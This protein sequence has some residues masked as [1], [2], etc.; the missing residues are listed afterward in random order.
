M[1]SRVVMFS[2]LAVV[3]AVSANPLAAQEISVEQALQDRILG[4]PG[5]PIAIVEYASFT[6]PQCA[7]FH[8]ETMPELK[9][10]WIDTGKAKLIYRDFPLDKRAAAASVVA[11]C[12]PPERYF[13]I[14]DALYE[15]QDSWARAADSASS[16]AAVSR[17]TGLSS[18]EIEKCLGNQP[19]V[20]GV[21]KMRLDAQQTLGIKGTP[22]FI[23]QGKLVRGAVPFENLDEFLRSLE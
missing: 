23:I 21:L 12:A 17:L 18:S 22:T 15:Q 9:K 6:C 7:R 4:D 19:L 11:R 2:V 14:V 13:E 20:D 3:L 16:Q 5:A 8:L 1:N 10:V